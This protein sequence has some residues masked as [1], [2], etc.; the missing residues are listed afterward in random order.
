MDASLNA[1]SVMIAIFLAVNPNY[2]K[3]VFK[4][5]VGIVEKV[6]SLKHSCVEIVRIKCASSANNIS[7]DKNN[8]NSDIIK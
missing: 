4:F 3:F 2:V 5:Y 8:Q 6:S 1:I 7:T